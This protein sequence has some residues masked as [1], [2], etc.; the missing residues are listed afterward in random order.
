MLGG[1][2]IVVAVL[3][4]LGLVGEL[5]VWML[6]GMLALLA[7]GALDDAVALTP[8]CK[9]LAQLA[10]VA[11]FL[12]AGPAAPEVTR[13]PLVNLGAGGF[14]DGRRDQRLQPG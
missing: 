9:L 13:W 8:S 5:P 10:V 3:A 2:A 14:L 4:A 1:I 7:V 11:F 12:W 6:A